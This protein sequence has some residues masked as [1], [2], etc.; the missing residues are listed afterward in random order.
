MWC[1][2]GYK[3][4][5]CQIASHNGNGNKV[6]KIL[7]STTNEHGKNHMCEGIRKPTEFSY[8][9]ERVKWPLFV[10]LCVYLVLVLVVLL[11]ASAFVYEFVLR[12]INVV[13]ISQPMFF[14]SNLHNSCAFILC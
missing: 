3:P 5:F 13:D 11:C 2:V 6:A 4:K 1:A 10:S 7:V 14:I 8:A 12:D 9:C